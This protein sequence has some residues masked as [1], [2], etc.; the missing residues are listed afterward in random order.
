MHDGAAELAAMWWPA[1]CDAYQLE[2]EIREVLQALAEREHCTP[3]EALA[4]ALRRVQ[5]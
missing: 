5:I 2:P 3:V 4:L 1:V